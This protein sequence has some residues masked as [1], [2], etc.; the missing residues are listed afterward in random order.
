L[1]KSIEKH[2]LYASVNSAIH[3]S[4]LPLIINRLSLCYSEITLILD[5]NFGVNS[6]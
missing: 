2:L 6:L 4:I 1:T 5:L 3:Q